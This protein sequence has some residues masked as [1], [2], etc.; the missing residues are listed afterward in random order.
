[1]V[2]LNTKVKVSLVPLANLSIVHDQSACENVPLVTVDP[3]NS[4]FAAPGITSLT[5]MFVA[6]EA[7]PALLTVTVKVTLFPT[8]V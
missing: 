6:F 3:T 7:L 4:R 2:V 5:L 8:I 1:M